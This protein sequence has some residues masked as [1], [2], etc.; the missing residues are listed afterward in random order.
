[1]SS[2]RPARRVA[3]SRDNPTGAHP[4]RLTVHLDE[5]R[6]GCGGL[7]YPVYLREL[8]KLDPEIPLMLEHL[9]NEEEYRMA[10][11]HLRSVAERE[12]GKG[13]D[14]LLTPRLV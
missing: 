14:A 12:P 2:A 7:D 4:D 1:M 8:A 9:P 6:P 3:T 10:A 13:G 11:D 5:T